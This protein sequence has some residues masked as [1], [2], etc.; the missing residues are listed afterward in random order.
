METAQF[1]FS[2]GEIT[3]KLFARVDLESFQSSLKSAYNMFVHKQGSIS[4]RPGT[5]FIGEVK[6][7]SVQTRLIPFKFSHEQS[8]ILE[9]GDY[10]M[11]IIKDGGY[12]LYPSGH[13][14][15]FQI[16]EITTPY[17]VEDVFGLKFAQ[18]ADIM[19]I[20][21]PSYDVRYLS[22]ADHH[23][24]TFDTVA[25]EADIDP[26]TSPSGSIV[27][28]T[29]TDTYRYKIVSVKETTEEQSAPT[30]AFEVTNVGVSGWS[31]DL[32]WT[33]AAGAAK[34]DIYREKSGIFGYIGSSST[35]EFNDKNIEPE[36]GDTPPVNNNP[37]D[38]TDDKPSC[39][40]YHKQRA[41]FAATNNEPE[42]LWFSQT[43]LFRNMNAS[44][45]LKAD[46]AISTR[47]TGSLVSKIYNMVSMKD[48]LVFTDS[49]VWTISSDGVFK[50]TNLDQSQQE[51]LGADDVPPLIIG[52]Q[53][54]FVEKGGK[55]VR[56]IG[57]SYASDDYT[58]NDLQI[59]SDHLLEDR[60]IIDWVY[61][62][63][64]NS[65][66]WAICDDGALLSLTYVAEHQIIAWCRHETDGEFESIATVREG[67]EDAVYFV[68][69][70]TIDG[71]TV[72][73]VERLHERNIST[74]E[75]G[76]FVDCGL[77]YDGAATDT[78]S[79]LDYLEGE[80]V[81]ILADGEELARATVTN[82]EITLPRSYTK[83]HVGIPYTSY[84]QTLAPDFNGN[85]MLIKRNKKVSNVQVHLYKS[86]FFKAGS[87]LDNLVE[88]KLRQFETPETV[89][90][91]KTGRSDIVID[92]S[93]EQS[94]SIF[95]VQDRPMPLTIAALIPTF[96]VA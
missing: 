93:Y 31:I 26:P 11:R 72:R 95:I 39:T 43:S 55:G 74:L 41:A 46:D 12:V 77:T 54:I 5:E 3:P 94:G 52:N 48:L 19:T 4:N 47:L 88:A 50:A 28:G 25:F 67:L 71:S 78:L 40:A 29:G 24:W 79:G 10:Y 65:I 1:S 16:V 34:Y 64:P 96:E 7:S 68:V 45:P 32:T 27:Y 38:D 83:V 18:S 73:Y 60:K 51:V 58:G 84:I 85:P 20:V 80:E 66:V 13:A 6:D 62:H 61:A 86:A 91:L 87:S 89:I 75:D 9:F 23:D 90:D 56:N 42:A 76:F 15:E 8:Y 35:N 17:A 44:S 63:K 57:Y 70:R 81:A 92:S 2:R 30:A 22:R 33:A 21:H 14:S 49:G 59:F 69:K 82:G 37:F 53:V 36:L